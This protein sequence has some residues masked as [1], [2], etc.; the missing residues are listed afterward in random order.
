MK[1]GGKTYRGQQGKLIKHTEKKSTVSLVKHLQRAEL[2]SSKSCFQPQLVC[3]P[4]TCCKAEEKL[5]A[6]AL[7]DYLYF[8]LTGGNRKNISIKKS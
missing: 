8:M 4:K 5:T 1:G 2:M 7:R 3:H 6:Q